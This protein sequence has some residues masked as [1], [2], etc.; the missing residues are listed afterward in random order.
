MATQSR[1]YGIDG[2]VYTFKDAY[3]RDQMSS[4]I[5]LA[6]VINLVYPIGTIFSSTS[7]TNPQTYLGGT[8]IQ[9]KDRMLLGAGSSYTAGNTGGS[10]THTITISEMPSHNHTFTGSAVT[11]SDISANHTHSGTTAVQGANHTHTGTSGNE[12]QGHTH[13]GPS[14]YHNND[15]LNCSRGTYDNWRAAC[16]GNDTTCGGTK[17]GGTGLSGWDSADHKHTTSF[18]IQNRGHTHSLTTDAVTTNHTHSITSAGSI[19]NKGDGTAFNIMPPYRVV[20][21]WK[22]TA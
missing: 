7:S 11:T 17:E 12:N 3:A 16:D 15:I 9:L 14:H 19:G 8:W 13:T 4:A 22:R 21:M 1:V 6:Q 20:Y 2:T 10:A 18:D 5:T